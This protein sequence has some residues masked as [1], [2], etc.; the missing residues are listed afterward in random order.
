MR[1]ALV[2]ILAAAAGPAAA[3]AIPAHASWTQLAWSNGVGAGFFDTS[4]RRVKGFRDHLY[5]SGAHELMYDAYFGLRV[6]GQEAWL[7]ARPV[8][9]AGYDGDT[10]IAEVQQSLLGVQVTERFVA[11]FGTDAAALVMLVD[12]K[13]TTASALADSALFS[14]ENLHVGG[15][16][17]QTTGESITWAPTAGEF[18][19]TGALGVLVH[20]PLPAP[21]VHACSP[22]NPYAAV[23]TGGHMVSTDASGTIDDAVP[24]FEWDLSGLAPGATRTFAVVLAFRGD[25]DAAALDAQLAALATDPAQ[26]E[27]DAQADWAAYQAGATEPA[28]LSPDEHAVYRRQLAILRMGQV[29]ES[30][31]GHGQIVASLPPGQWNIAWVRDQSYAVLALVRAGLAQPAHDALAFWLGAQAGG[32]VCCDSTGGPWVGAPYAISVVR[33]TGAGVEES[34]SNANGPNIEFDGFGLALGALDDYVAA[35]GDLSLVS[36]NQDAVFAKTAD[37]LAGLVEPGG[38]AAGLL[39]AD[40]SIWEEHWYG[41]GRKHFAYTDAAAVRGLRAAA[42]L[43]TRAG[44]ASD[45]S[46]YTA[47]A[48]AIT[49][50]FATAL[51]DPATGAVRGN[52]EETAW[53][54]AAPV[55]AFNWDVLDKAGPAA[56][57]SLDAWKTGLW[58]GLTGHGYHRDDD[59]G[60]YDLMEWIVIDLR[61]GTALRRAG[62]PGEADALVAW[63]TE[64][65]RANFELVPENYDPTTAD[66]A[67]AVPMVGFGAGAYVLALWDRGAVAP[68]SPDGAPIGGDAGTGP[69]PAPGG[70]CDAGRAPAPLVPLV[71]ALLALR[72]RKRA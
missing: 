18:R 11:P 43:A 10:G 54:D 70:C 27:A 24:G 57:A 60:S 39:R 46:R 16:S 65:A 15:G 30:G 47:A 56:T 17:A 33:Y 26:L 62:R 35:T 41:G 38:A 69:A 32:W 6:G 71:L 9:A 61:V 36:G 64:Q 48:D 20:R 5:A 12:A 58:N 21:T 3:Q 51:V 40:S 29:R 23:M 37:V 4:V 8:E 45:A 34:D 7:T 13:N 53:L 50:A 19:E 2:V 1:T 55:E 72:R 49:S 14:I 59:G 67:G 52:L 31:A 63:V 28:G 44:R 66:Y 22:N 42:D 68:M 25:G